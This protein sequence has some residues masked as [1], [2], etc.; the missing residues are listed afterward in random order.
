MS[1]IK[2]ALTD[3]TDEEVRRVALTATVAATSHPER[4]A[5]ASLFKALAACGY[6]VSVLLWLAIPSVLLLIYR[7]LS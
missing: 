7:S 2:A 3:M 4:A 1:D 6:A 5:L